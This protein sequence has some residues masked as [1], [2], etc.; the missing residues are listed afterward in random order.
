MDMLWY[1]SLGSNIHAEL[2]LAI[3][4]ALITTA[5]CWENDG[6]QSKGFENMRY[7]NAWTESKKFLFGFECGS[8]WQ[9]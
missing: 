3:A 1:N 9:A 5:L 8:C 4:L 2:Y 6:D 7:G